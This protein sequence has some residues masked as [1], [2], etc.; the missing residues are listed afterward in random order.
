MLETKIVGGCSSLLGKV[1]LPQSLWVRPKYHPASLTASVNMRAH[2]LYCECL[3]L[4]L[5]SSYQYSM[6]NDVPKP[7][8]LLQDAGEHIEAQLWSV[9]VHSVLS[10]EN[11]Y[12][13]RCASKIANNR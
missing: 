12:N 5:S 13:R 4:L 8:N 11:R 10:N 9:Q 1:H 7:Y 2:H 3:M 6:R